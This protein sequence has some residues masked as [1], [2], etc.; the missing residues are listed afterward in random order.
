MCVVGVW[1]AAC[2]SVCI[3]AVD[4]G[5][6]QHC[7]ACNP[8]FSALLSVVR[9]L[10]ESLHGHLV[11]VLFPNETGVR[12]PFAKPLVSVSASSTCHVGVPSDLFYFL[13]IFTQIVVG[14]TGDITLVLLSV[15]CLVFVD[16]YNDDDAVT[17]VM[18]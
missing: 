1:G 16:N 13:L 12:R 7:I 3:P 14:L 5:L 10:G 8:V 15:L 11:K 18:V 2:V 9:L 6:Q 17:V 4:G